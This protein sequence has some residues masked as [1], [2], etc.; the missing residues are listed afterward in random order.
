MRLLR[1]VRIVDGCYLRV[2]CWFCVPVFG[3]GPVWKNESHPPLLLL[4]A[5]A[6]R[7][8]RE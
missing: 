3:C 1:C 6:V 8:L 2:V 5:M 4:A 7:P